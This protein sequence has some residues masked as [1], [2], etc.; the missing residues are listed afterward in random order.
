MTTTQNFNEKLKSGVLYV[1]DTS[2]HETKLKSL[3]T[4]WTHVRV[5]VPEDQTAQ[6]RRKGWR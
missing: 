2:S 6:K 1:A 3:A 4:S 5:L